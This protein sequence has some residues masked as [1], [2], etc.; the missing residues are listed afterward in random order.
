M[1]KRSFTVD[2]SQK[3]IRLDKY[4][5]LK[6]EGFSRE[7][8]KELFF[9]EDVLLN[10]KKAKPSVKV[11]ENDI[12]TVNIPQIK[13]L[14]IKK[15]NIPIDVIYEDKDVI[16][17][18]KPQ[19]MVV[20][21]ADGNYDKT[22]V[23]ALLYHCENLSAINGV[24]RPGIVHRID[25]DT[26]GLIIAAKNDK[27]H[28]HLALQFKEHTITR[29]YRAIVH[30]IIGEN[31]GIIDAPIGRNPI[32]RKEMCVIQKNSKNAVTHF[33]VI[34]RLENYTFL[35][36]RLETGRTHQIRVHMKYIFHPVVGDKLYGYNRSI[37]KKFSGQ[38]LHAYELGFIHP[39]TNEYMHFSCDIPE[40]FYD[41]L[42]KNIN[43]RL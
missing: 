5:S 6:I 29:S 31:E 17:V 10:G 28:N 14:E 38:L 3:G 30:G 8:L 27:A 15:E 21:P 23:N 9:S 39:T 7:K 11:N 13:E 22:L 4:L 33:K 42:D 18:N 12:V 20:H 25:K 36:L 40:Y 35:A 2:I 37:D 34:E 19:G 24:I 1:D 43:Y 16:V 32:K 41:I 26:S